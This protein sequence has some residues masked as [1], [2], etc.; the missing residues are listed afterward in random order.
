MFEEFTAHLV[1]Y[2]VRVSGGDTS[3]LGLPGALKAGSLKS[4]LL[5]IPTNLAVTNRSVRIRSIDNFVPDIAKRAHIRAAIGEYINQT[6]WPSTTVQESQRMAGKQHVHVVE[7]RNSRK[8][9]RLGVDISKSVPG[10]CT[11]S[12]SHGVGCSYDASKIDAY[13]L[14]ILPKRAVVKMNI[15]DPKCFVSVED[16]CHPAAGCE[17]CVFCP[18]TSVNGTTYWQV[19][20][21][22]I[23]HELGVSTTY[24]DNIT[25]HHVYDYQTMSS[26]SHGF[27]FGIVS[28]THTTTKFYEMY[29]RNDTSMSIIAKSVIHYSLSLF[30]FGNVPTPEFSLAVSLLPDTYDLLHYRQFL[31]EWGTHFM[32]QADMGAMALV[33]NYFHKCFLSKYNENDVEDQSFATFVGIYSDGSHHVHGNSQLD[34]YFEQWSVSSLQLI[35][36]DALHYGFAGP[37]TMMNGEKVQSWE[38]SSR[39][40]PSPVAYTMQPIHALIADTKKVENVKAAIAQYMKD[41]KMRNDGLIDSLKPQDPD[42]IPPWC[43]APGEI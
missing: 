42:Y 20:T 43:H 13:G 17:A 5:S 12:G 33:T 40:Q 23:P 28:D 31:D 27:D 2:S 25:A 7:A 38:R 14:S 41:A 15:C 32:N 30:P 19:P 39:E 34:Q 24:F 6:N 4:W 36:G 29:F 22:V 9:N 1:D 26:A 3:L 11:G 18:F 37:K 35:G 10:V 21:N 8:R 16:P